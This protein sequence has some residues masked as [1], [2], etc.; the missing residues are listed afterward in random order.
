MIR[1]LCDRISVLDY[2]VETVRRREMAS[3]RG[4]AHMDGKGSLENVR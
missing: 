4:K 1:F 2:S 3:G